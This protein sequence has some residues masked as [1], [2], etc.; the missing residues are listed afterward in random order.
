MTTTLLTS[1]QT[2]NKTSSASSPM[3]DVTIPKD[4]VRITELAAKKILAIAEKESKIGQTLRVGI[5]GGGCSGLSYSFQFVDKIHDA[6]KV[7][8]EYDASICI[9]PKSMLYLGGTLLD[10]SES[11]MKSG[12]ILRNPNQKASCSCGESFTV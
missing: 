1:I 9:D 5:M 8:T 3:T 6:D 11:L 4:T 2:K 10:W 7:F 12:F